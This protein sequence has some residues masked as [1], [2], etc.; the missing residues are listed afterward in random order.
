[1]SYSKLKF[2]SAVMT[3]LRQQKVLNF[4]LKMAL[5]GEYHYISSLVYNIQ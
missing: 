1:M 4:S 5:L 3:H 2:D